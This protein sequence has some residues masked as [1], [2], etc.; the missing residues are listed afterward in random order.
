MRNI[1][2]VTSVSVA[3]S[4]PMV[5]LALM[6]GMTVGQDTQI[7]A[8]A[9]VYIG[10]HL[11][12]TLGLRL[13]AGRDFSA[14]EEAMPYQGTGLNQNGPVIITRAL[15]RKLFPREQPL[16]KVVR[17]G[18]DSDAG[19]HTVIGVIAHLMRN[20]FGESKH[21]DLDY[22]MLFPSIPGQWPIP[23]FG[24]RFGASNPETV[25][26][27]VNDVIQ[28]M[29]GDT[30]VQGVYPQFEMYVQLRDRALAKTR[31]AVWLLAGVSLI[32][33][34]VTLVGI[35]GMT[36]YWVQQRTRQI[37]IRRALG[38]R[39]GDILRHLQMENL[40]V[41]GAGVALGLIAALVINLWLMHHYE[42][43][44]L[45]WQ[46]LPFGAALMLVLGQV[47]VLAPALRASRVAPV[48]ATRS[49]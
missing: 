16:G 40:L 21:G 41:V 7:Q 30:L 47:A 46:Y 19:R 12:K 22:T 14:E 3:G 8:N 33:L 10:V 17:L 5:T 6:N 36:G 45:P 37:G 49:V 2:G 39:R 42:L 31:A 48:V 15:A 44:R 34:V 1:P 18:R 25:R 38:A 4:M 24:V 27:A 43:S 23:S 13:V 20:D 32:V 29:L 28:R 11:I 35:M 9:A 26:K